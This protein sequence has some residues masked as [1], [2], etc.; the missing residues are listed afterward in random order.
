[1]CLPCLNAL[2]NAA[3]LRRMARESQM[4]LLEGCTNTGDEE[5]CNLPASSGQSRGSFEDTE[6]YDFVDSIKIE[7]DNFEN[8]YDDETNFDF[9]FQTVVAREFVSPMKIELERNGSKNGSPPNFEIKLEPMDEEKF[10][11]I[12]ADTLICCKTKFTSLEKFNRHK[13]LVH[14][15]LC[16]PFICQTCYAGFLTRPDLCEHIKHTHGTKPVEE[17]G[18]KQL[19]LLTQT[20]KFIGFTCC[21][22]KFRSSKGYKH[23]M[24]KVHPEMRKPKPCTCL[25][26]YK[27]FGNR[28]D[29]MAHIREDHGGSSVQVTKCE[30]CGKVCRTRKILFHHI[31]TMHRDSLIRAM[32]EHEEKDSLRGVE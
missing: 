12:A 29:L 26:C 9:P 1:M 16:E 20:P 28:K 11:S 30:T 2:E 15:E 10:D 8:T 4:A 23:H 32:N 25:S 19:Q 24:Q 3:E 13:Y 7:E 21:K 6:G 17:A 18:E 14:P 31:K 22:L 5:D 27:Q